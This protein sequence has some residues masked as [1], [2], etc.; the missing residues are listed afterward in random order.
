M[1]GTQAQMQSHSPSL[2]FV[3]SGAPF[4]IYSLFPP[5]A[6]LNDKISLEMRSSQDSLGGFARIYRTPMSSGRLVAVKVFFE[7]KWI[8]ERDIVL[9]LR[10]ALIWQDL[11][12]PNVVPFLGIANYQAICAGALPQLCLVSP[13]MSAGN[14]M[15]YIASN[16]EESRLPFVRHP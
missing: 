11:N 6:N 3:C 13:W 14:I 2:Q 9:S 10:E 12:H 4:R 5:S 16:P 1:R 8:H 15:E 7:N